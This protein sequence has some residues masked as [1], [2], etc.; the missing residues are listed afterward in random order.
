MNRV[1]AIE[2]SLKCFAC[3]L[4]ALVP[5]FGLPFAVAAVFLYMKSSTHSAGDW[6]PARR[7]G[8]L[9]L[10]FALIGSCV[11][12]TALFCTIAFYLEDMT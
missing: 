9:G 6:N 5:L 3:G 1:V 7:Y 4:L 8:L 11:T 10:A 2:S 12:I